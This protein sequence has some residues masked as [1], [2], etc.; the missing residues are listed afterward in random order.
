LLLAYNKKKITEKE[1]IKAGKKASE[2]GLKY[3]ILSLGELPKKV[4]ELIDALK[5]IKTIGKV[6]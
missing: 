3:S 2:N 5:D 4:S 1:I 6:E